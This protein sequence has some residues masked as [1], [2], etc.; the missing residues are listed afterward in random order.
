MLEQLARSHQEELRR[1]GARPGRR[2]GLADLAKESFPR[3]RR[4][5]QRHHLASVTS[6]PARS[7]VSH[8]RVA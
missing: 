7:G 5:H 4:R 6:L 2:G 1:L 3:L 8:G